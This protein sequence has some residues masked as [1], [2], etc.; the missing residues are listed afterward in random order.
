MQYAT[1]RIGAIL[2]TINPAYRTHELTYVLNQAGVSTLISAESFRTSDYRAMITEASPACHSLRTVI[3]L[4]T[5]DWTTLLA[6]ARTVDTGRAGRARGG[7]ELRR[8]DQH[9]VHVRDHRVPQGRDAVA[10]QHPEQRVLRGP[11][12]GLV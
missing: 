9:P 1:A 3:Y 6:Q 10:P 8:P 12:A 4:G 2:V 11:A 5:S 7:A